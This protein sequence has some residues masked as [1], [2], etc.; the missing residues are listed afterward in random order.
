MLLPIRMADGVLHRNEYLVFSTVSPKYRHLIQ[1][2]NCRFFELRVFSIVCFLLLHP[3]PPICFQIGQIET[4]SCLRLPFSP[5]TLE[6]DAMAVQVH[7]NADVGKTLVPDPTGDTRIPMSSRGL[8]RVNVS[9]SVSQTLLKGRQ[10]ARGKGTWSHAVV[11][12]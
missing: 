3:N 4:C 1:T 5:S 12:K 7:L 9:N 8:R 6:L 2:T 11:C 10:Y